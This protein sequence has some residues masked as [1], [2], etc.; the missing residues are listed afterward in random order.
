MNAVKRLLPLD[1]VFCTDHVGSKDMLAY[2]D[3]H[4]DNEQTVLYVDT[5]GEWSSGFDSADILKQIVAD[6]HYSSFELLYQ[7]GS[8]EVYILTMN[9]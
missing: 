6:T 8:S 9:N 7:Y 3:T 4:T 2:I 5:D 1:D